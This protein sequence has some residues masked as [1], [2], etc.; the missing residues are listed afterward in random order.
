VALAISLVST[1]ALQGIHVGSGA[2]LLSLASAVNV[3]GT[4]GTVVDRPGI[5]IG[6]LPRHGIGVSDMGGGV[7]VAEG[8]SLGTTI[9]DQGRFGG[10][11]SDRERITLG[12]T[13]G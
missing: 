11:A 5:G 6:D 2:V 1:T 9:A 13:D 10:S 4:V 7:S 12:V 8:I 3:S